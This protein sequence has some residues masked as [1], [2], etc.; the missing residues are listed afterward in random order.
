MAKPTPSPKIPDQ[1]TIEAQLRQQLETD[2]KVKAWFEKYRK[3]SWDYFIKQYAHSKHSALLYPDLYIDDFKPAHK[4]FNFEAR[5]ALEA[6]QEKKLFNLQCEWR[7]G[8]IQLPFVQITYDFELIGRKLLMDCPFLPPVTL[9]EV[10]LFIQY[11]QSN[12][13]EDLDLHDMYFWQKYEDIKIEFETD[14]FGVTPSWYEFYDGMRGTGYLIRLPNTRGEKE[15]AYSQLGWEHANPNPAP[16]VPNPEMEKPSADHHEAEIDFALCFETPELAETII[17]HVK[18]Q[19]H[20]NDHEE[21][22][23]W[24]KYLKSI[25]ETIP[26]VPHHDWRESLRLTIK[27]YRNQKIAEALPRVWRQYIRPFGNDPEA[28]VQ[29]RIAEAD[30]DLSKLDDF[31]L[32]KMIVKEVLNGRELS[33]EPRD[34]DY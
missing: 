23:G 26:F 25:P 12:D 5:L 18:T 16:Y 34:F 29:K 7:A 15:K 3:H 1:S 19:R 33:G 20:R 10:E 13:S 30:F 2:P 14:E 6:I 4:E 22:D 17:S 32:R 11:L 31:G 21:L 28:Y 24:Y 27:S 8:S 9:D